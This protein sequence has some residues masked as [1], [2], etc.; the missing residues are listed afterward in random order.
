MA[1]FQNNSDINQIADHIFVLLDFKTLINLEQINTQWS[2]HLR[3][4]KVWLR[5]CM[6]KEAKWFRNQDQDSNQIYVDYRKA[7]LR[8]YN[9]LEGLDDSHD[10]TLKK[11][12]LMHLK[13]RFKT[14]LKL[15]ATFTYIHI[16]PFAFAAKCGN[17]AL[18]K[19]I[20]TKT[21]PF[22]KMKRSATIDVEQGEIL[23]DEVVPFDPSLIPIH[24][25]ARFGHWKVVKYLMETFSHLNEATDEFNLTP[26]EHAVVENHKKVVK[27]LLHF[28]MRDD[29]K[30]RAFDLAIEKEMYTI[31]FKI[32][33][34]NAV[35]NINRFVCNARIGR[36]YAVPLVCLIGLLVNGI[37]FIGQLYMDGVI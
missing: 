5:L 14:A 11:S 29:I 23:N 17:L 4:P 3:D 13:L 27:Y 26:I 36:F 31:A 24:T 9:L 19:H 10:D 7:N 35:R 30:T 15:T 16:T 8:W 18:V 25:A 28:P 37:F 22:K 12:L 2:R 34:W 21:D 33:K 32:N 20:V 1:L 6:K